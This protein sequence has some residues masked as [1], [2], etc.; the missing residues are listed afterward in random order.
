VVL[1]GSTSEGDLIEAV[2]PAW[3]EIVRQLKVDPDFLFKIDPRKLEELIAGAY[4]K[5]GYTDVVLTPRSGDFGRDV[6]A[7][8]KDWGQVRFIDQVKAY[9]PGHLVTAEE[10]RALGHVLQADRNATKG[11][12]TTTSDFAP[13]VREDPFIKPYLPYRIELLNGAALLERLR[14]IS[15]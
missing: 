13:R 6:I 9:K 14:N 5:A 8:R 12:V 15:E 1:G 2:A 7:S 11:F 10:I 4:H 3:L